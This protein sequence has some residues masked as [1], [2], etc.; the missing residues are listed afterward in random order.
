[1]AG[2]GTLLN[3]RPSQI[4]L[5]I[6]PGGANVVVV[7]VVEGASVAISHVST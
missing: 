7:V 3:K 6:E 4:S 5:G 2:C 1:M